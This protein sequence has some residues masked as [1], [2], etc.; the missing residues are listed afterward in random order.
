MTRPKARAR[1]GN[2]DHRKPPRISN[3]GVLVAVWLFALLV[4]ALY[5][6]QIAQAPFYDLRLGDAEAYHLWAERIAAGDWLGQTVFY[7]APLYPYL[8]AIVYRLFGDSVTVVRVAQALV[9]A[10]SCALV[11]AAGISWFDRRGALAGVLLAIYPPA[12]FL[13]GLLEKSAV[14]TFLTAALLACLV[15]T[16]NRLSLLRTTGAGVLL[17]L[18]ALTRE[19]ALLLAVPAGLWLLYGPFAKEQRLRSALAFLAPAAAILLCVGVRN[20]A[21]GREFHLTTSQFGPNF[22]IGNHP[23]ASGTYE[24]LSEGHGNAID[25]QDDATRIAEQATGRT[26]TPAAVSDYWTGRAFDYVRAQPKAWLALLVRKSGLMLNAQEIA[27]TES[28]EVYAEWA[29][30]LWVLRPFDFGVLIALSAL[31]TVLTASSWRRLWLLYGIALTYAL[32]VVAF[33]VFARYRFP[34]VPVLTILAAGGLLTL[35]DGTERPRRV[36]WSVVAA[37]A[38]VAIAH[39]PLEN[40][41]TTR[42][43]HYAGIGAAMTKDER[44]FD[45]AMEFYERALAEEPGLPAAQ[46]GVATLLT[47]SGRAS[48]A[49]PHFEAVLRAWPSQA[50]ARYNFGVALAAVGRLDEA[51]RQLQEAVRLRHNDVDARNALAKTLL[52]LERPQEALAQYDQSLALQPRTVKALVGSGV[53]LTQLGR[54]REAIERYERALQLNP[55]EA[56]AHNNLGFT[57]ASNGRIAEAVPHFER[58]LALNPRDENARRNLEQAKKSLRP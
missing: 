28:Q 48:E 43:T 26:L 50:E 42:A 12:I 56:D 29:S 53:A 2:T 11:A 57:L 7:Q 18:L 22:Y 46:F 55:D 6:W 24:A 17:A 23:G 54:P 34:L 33:Y 19:N 3:A 10:S 21:V 40:S 49:I 37:V 25:E 14:V 8:L 16:T 38:A 35:V 41:R 32:S 31:G 45:L 39:L 47:R 27:D 5:L 1:A 13:D 44:R 58:A 4:R 51:E 30:V 15:T 20:Y 36:G 9:G 52:A